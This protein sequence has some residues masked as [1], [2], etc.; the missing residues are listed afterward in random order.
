[1]FDVPVLEVM[2][3]LGHFLHVEAP[4]TIAARVARWLA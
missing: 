1:L 2:P 3:N 4:A